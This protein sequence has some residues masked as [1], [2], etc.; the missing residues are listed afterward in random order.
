MSCLNAYHIHGRATQCVCH[1]VCLEMTCKSKVSWRTRETDEGVMVMFCFCFYSLLNLHKHILSDSTFRWKSL[2]ILMVMLVELDLRPPARHSK[3]FWG[4]RSLW[5]MPL[6]YRTF[7]ACAICCRNT[8][9]V[10]SLRVPL[11]VDTEESQ[12]E[13]T[14]NIYYT[15][16]YSCETLGKK[17]KT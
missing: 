4:L 8:R 13:S 3:M 1:T 16:A 9:M 17:F 15:G 6:L 14:E 10:S 7:M 5:R 11:A 2:P 12:R